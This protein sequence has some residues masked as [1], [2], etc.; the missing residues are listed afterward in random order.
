MNPKL[1]E[2]LLND[3]KQGDFFSQ[4]KQEW[5]DIGDFYI[6]QEKREALA[7]KGTIERWILLVWWIMKSM[8]L[9]LTPVR[10]NPHRP[11]APSDSRGGERPFPSMEIPKLLTTRSWALWQSWSS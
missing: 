6:T 10:T 8:F 3:V 2:T 9:K 1:T 4:F 11:G 7:R 5:R